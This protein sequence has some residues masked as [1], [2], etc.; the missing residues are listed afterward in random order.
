MVPAI[1][2]VKEQYAF[3]EYIVQQIDILVP[4]PRKYKVTNS[5]AL[6]MI[7]YRLQHATPWYS[8]ESPYHY[9]T[10]LKRS[11]L[12]RNEN[13]FEQIWKSITTAYGNTSL[14][15]DNY[16][17]KNIIIDSSMAR[18]LQAYELIGRNYQ[19]KMKFG[20]KVSVICDKKG[21]PISITF[22][23]SN[24]HDIKTIDESL[25]SIPMAIIKNRRFSNNLLGD[26]GYRSKDKTLELKMTC[27][28]NLI[29]NHK[30]NEKNKNNKKEWKLLQKRYRI[31]NV[32]A[33]LKQFKRLMFR[34]DRKIS[35]YKSFF[36][37]ASVFLTFSEMNKH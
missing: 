32:F 1:L 31:E 14:S 10:F 37:L 8:I 3:Y 4:H 18:N 9:N 24:V 36:F 23:P 16:Y 22:Y 35:T 27:Q 2:R 7:L 33:R 34:Y 26:K 20:T 6:K 29:A 11:E 5:E 21:I 28:L 12:W 15:H 19:D 30:S 25:S 13:V 17:F